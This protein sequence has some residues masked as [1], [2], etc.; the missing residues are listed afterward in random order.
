MLP[1]IR[2]GKL[3][4][5][6]VTGAQRSPQVPDVPTL[7]ESGFAGYSAYVWL[8]LLA[9]KGTPAA[10]VERLNREVL[11]ALDSAEV[12][13]YMANA[14]IEALGSSPAEFGAFFR[15]ER[16]NWAKVIKETGAK[17]D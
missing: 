9:P 13:T 10:V 6:A 1:H 4:A 8:G 15:A 11:S 2:S 12:K 14:S 16:D 17:L 3:R 5:L 7:A